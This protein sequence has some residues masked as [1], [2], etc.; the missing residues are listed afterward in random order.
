M[1]LVHLGAQQVISLRL[2]MPAVGNWTAEVEVDG[3]E[4]PAG[5]ASITFAV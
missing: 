3:D 1:S 4:P 5:A 2:A